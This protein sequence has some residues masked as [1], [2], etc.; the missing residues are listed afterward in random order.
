MPLSVI[1]VVIVSVVVVVAA[2]ATVTDAIKPL[3]YFVEYPVIEFSPLY[4]C[5]NS[6]F[7][8]N[9]SIRL[10]VNFVTNVLS[11]L[12]EIIENLESKKKPRIFI[13]CHRFGRIL[14]LFVYFI[15]R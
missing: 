11:I 3:N 10:L 15:V 8:S 13:G 2:V 1:T 6:V 9:S 5:Y 7:F 14:V 12:A 4:Q